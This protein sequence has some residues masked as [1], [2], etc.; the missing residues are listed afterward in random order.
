MVFGSLDS[1]DQSHESCSNEPLLDHQSRLF[2]LVTDAV[3]DV[4]TITAFLVLSLYLK[5]LTGWSDTE[6]SFP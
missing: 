2:L 1:A 3:R 4:S 6:T 5:L